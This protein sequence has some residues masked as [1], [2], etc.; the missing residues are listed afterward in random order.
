M[1]S[2]EEYTE[3]EVAAY[4]EWRLMASQQEYEVE[5]QR[6]V[7]SVQAQ[8]PPVLNLSEPVFRLSDG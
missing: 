4:V 5:T 1:E 6:R 2:D 3:S 8:S 7:D